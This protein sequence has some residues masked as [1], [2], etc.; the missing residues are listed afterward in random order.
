MS[1]ALGPKMQGPGWSTYGERR[2]RGSRAGSASGEATLEGTQQ[3]PDSTMR[4]HQKEPWGSAVVHGSRRGH[5]LWEETFQPCTR[6]NLLTCRQR[7]SLSRAAA[8]P[9]SVPG[10]FQN[11]PGHGPEQTGSELRA[12]PAQ[13]SLQP[14]LHPLRSSD[15]NRAVCFL[16]Y[17]AFGRQKRGLFLAE[18][19]C[20]TTLSLATQ[21]HCEIHLFLAEK[22][23]SHY[24]SI[25]ENIM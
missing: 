14:E 3:L 11:P 6:R 24:F 8:H 1:S 4:G 13:G 20:S 15:D 9:P 12:N 25:H 22:Q 21:W 16:S 2:G 18:A 7:H 5:K 10:R 23:T 19:T 17:P